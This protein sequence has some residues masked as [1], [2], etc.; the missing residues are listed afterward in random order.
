M[1]PLFVPLWFVW[2]TK[3]GHKGSHFALLSGDFLNSQTRWRSGW[4]SN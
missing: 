1:T 3:T 4:D 2:A